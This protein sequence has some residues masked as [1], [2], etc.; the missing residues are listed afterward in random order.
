MRITGF[1]E[2]IDPCGTMRDAGQPQPRASLRRPGRTAPCP[3]SRTLPPSMRPGGLD[4]A[5]D[6]QR[7]GGLAASRTRRPG[8]TARA[9]A[10][11]KL[12]SSTARTSPSGWSNDT[13]RS[14]DAQ[15]RLAHAD[16]PQPRVGDL[17]QPDGEK[18]RPRK[19]IT[20]ITIGGSHHHHQPLMIAALKFTQ[21]SVMPS[22][23]A[24]TG[25]RPST[26]SPIEARIA[27]GYRAHQRRRQVG[28]Q[29]RHQLEEDD[30]GPAH[31]RSV[32]A[33]STKPRSR[34]R[35]HLRADG[36]RRVQPGQRGDDQR[37]LRSP[38]GCP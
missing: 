5:Q 24:S 37:H 11:V 20:M 23:G 27:A 3:S 22:V 34:K 8:R 2:F 17:V 29:V 36:A 14:V 31:A 30:L 1:S 7:H 33:I 32:A 18:N 12:T 35:Q 19:T 9:G 26:S 10:G 16:L 25:P 15:D 13:R 4:H 21:Y 38:S 28:Q 6:R